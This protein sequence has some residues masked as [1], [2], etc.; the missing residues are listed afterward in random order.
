MDNITEYFG[1]I[2]QYRALVQAENDK[3]NAE[4]KGLD[5]YKGSPFYE[6]RAAEI[7]NERMKEI[8]GYRDSI[9]K[10][11]DKVLA[12]MRENAARVLP[13]DVPTSDMIHIIE[14]LR[15][16]QNKTWDELREAAVI[17]QS[18]PQ[19]LAVVAEMAAEQN[20]PLPAAPKTYGSTETNS[21]IDELYRFARTTLQL[22][23]VNNLTEWF[24]MAHPEMSRKQDT[25][26]G[27]A[28]DFW[29]IDR[30]VADAKEMIM[31]AAAM[32]NEKQFT[33]F[34]AAVND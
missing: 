24:E 30:D 13:A 5:E 9:G 8:K 33:D 22:D 23:K 4:I 34:T 32:E 12:S 19:A 11:L 20:V 29:L 10:Q 7:E 2:K 3:V 31:K 6:R 28:L 27:K 17:C 26:G 14:L 18:N 16:K 1:L 15:L 25:T 21:A